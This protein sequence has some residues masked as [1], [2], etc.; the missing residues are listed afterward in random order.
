VGIRKTQAIV[1]GEEVPG[2]VDDEERA[3]GRVRCCT[4]ERR[5]TKTSTAQL[6]GLRGWGQRYVLAL[7]WAN[8]DM[9]CPGDTDD[10]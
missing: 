7:G 1:D 10:R 8:A 5:C 6:P 9:L 2:Q 3:S 4:S